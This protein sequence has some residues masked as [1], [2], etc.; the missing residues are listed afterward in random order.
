MI[1]VRLTAREITRL[2]RDVRRR[3]LRE[4]ANHAAKAGLYAKA[5]VRADDRAS[6]TINQ[7]K[8]M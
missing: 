6:V 4:S 8:G 7:T 3:I 5:A 2:P 1:Q